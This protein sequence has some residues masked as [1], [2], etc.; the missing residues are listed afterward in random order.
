MF[1][2]VTKPCVSALVC[3]ALVLWVAAK[4]AGAPPSP[5]ILR[6]SD[7]GLWDTGDIVGSVRSDC[8]GLRN[9]Q[10]DEHGLIHHLM[11]N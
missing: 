5:E 10:C 2:H 4:L 3:E 6:N 8:A 1:A 11:M 7:L 9:T